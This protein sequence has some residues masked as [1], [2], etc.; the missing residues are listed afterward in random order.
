MDCSTLLG[1]CRDFETSLQEATILG[2]EE[3]C[4]AVDQAGD[5]IWTPSTEM[6]CTNCEEICVNPTESTTYTAAWNHQDAYDCPF[7]QQITVQLLNCSLEDLAL[8]IDAEEVSH[9]TLRASANTAADRILTYQWQI[10]TTNCE[11]G[12]T[13]IEGAIAAT[14]TPVD[15]TPSTFFRVQITENG[16][17]N[18]ICTQVTSCIGL[19]KI[20]GCVHEDTNRDGNQDSEDQ[21][22]NGI[23]VG[24]YLCNNTTE[25]IAAT[26]T[27][28]KGEYCFTGLVSG[29]YIVQVEAP[30]NYLFPILSSINQEGYS[31]CINLGDGE[32]LIDCSTLLGACHDF[33]LSMFET[34]ILAGEEVCVTTNTGGDYI[35]APTEG[36]TC[37]DCE[38]VCFSPTETT[39]YT[40]TW[41]QQEVYTCSFARKITINIL[42]CSLADMGNKYS[43]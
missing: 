28:D 2:G 42:S 11:E 38:E 36:V 1:L 22:M 14:Y 7:S 19:G 13:D 23:P 29:D 34:A 40:A 12:F 16:A 43:I 37:S 18:E 3:V 24:L 17:G 25:A 10:S 41:D 9:P 27:D 21:L 33:E 6:S 31:S 4:I 15:L 20:G 5:Y 39:T 8:T 32:E 30:E 35:W 26:V